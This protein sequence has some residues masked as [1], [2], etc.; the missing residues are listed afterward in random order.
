MCLFRLVFQPERVHASADKATAASLGSPP[1]PHPLQWR[2]QQEIT[3]ESGNS[4]AANAAHF[5]SEQPSDEES[6]REGCCGFVRVCVC[7]YT[8]S[9]TLPDTQGFD[10]AAYAKRFE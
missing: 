4:S 6:V 8:L 2:P 1:D 3:G 9:L 10:F 5:P 7:V